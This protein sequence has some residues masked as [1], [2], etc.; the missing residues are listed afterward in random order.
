MSFSAVGGRYAKA[1]YEIGEETGQLEAL[2]RQVAAMAK[3]YTASMDLRGVIDNPL[4]PEPRREAILQAVAARLELG[5]LV[6]NLLRLMARRHRIGAL[7]DVARALRVL[8][9]Q[10]SGVLRATILSAAPLSEQ[11][12]AQITAQLERKT[13]RRIVAEHQHDPGL[14]AGVVTRIGDK[15]IDGS[16][17]GRLEALER[18]LLQP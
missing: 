13:Q 3:V 1:L 4:I 5:P 15:T 8:V 11:E 9:D 17:K 2:A 16:L 6:V 12:V 18:R 14:I 7:P 10:R